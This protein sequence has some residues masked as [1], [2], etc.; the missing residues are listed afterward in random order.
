M[1]KCQIPN[2]VQALKPDI[3]IYNEGVFP[4]GPESSTDVNVAFRKK[5]CSDDGYT[6]FDFEETKQIIAQ[7]AEDYPHIEWH[8]GT[9]EYPVGMSA[10]DAYSY[11]VSNFQ[12]Y[13]IEIQE[14]DILLPSEAD[15]FNME[16]DAEKIDEL[17]NAMQ[18]GEAI[19]TVWWDFGST[20]YYI[21]QRM[22]PDINTVTKSR[23]FAICFKAWEHY[24]G[25]IKNF[26]SQNYTTTTKLVDLKTYHYPWFSTGKYLKLRCD[27]LNR[28]P[29]YWNEYLKG[30]YKAIRESIDRT[31]EPSVMIRPTNTNNYR[32]IKYI[33]T[34][35]PEAIKYHGCWILE[36]PPIPENIYL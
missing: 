5:Y 27:I 2:I 35:H 22:H 33:D 32:F 26:T 9:I 15:A 6:G 23:R 13:G 29:G 11:A 18:P 1:I 8:L 20:Q 7:A 14:G 25:V 10:D 17:L 21:E 19:S 28:P 4:H 31:F 24:F 34:E 16:S 3:V 36:L 12:T 30:H